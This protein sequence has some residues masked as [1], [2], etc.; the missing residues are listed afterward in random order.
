M[1][2]THKNR[3]EKLQWNLKVSELDL[4]RKNL[5]LLLKENL[6]M[7]L[8]LIRLVFYHMLIKM[9]LGKSVTNTKFF[10]LK[11]CLEKMQQLTSLL[12]L[13]KGKIGVIF[14]VCM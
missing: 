11:F 3:S 5:I 2:K 10:M 7:E 14:H 1:H 12:I 13:L 4:T 6:Q 9:L 8:S